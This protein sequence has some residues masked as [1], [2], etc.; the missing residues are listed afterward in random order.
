MVRLTRHVLAIVLLLATALEWRGLAQEEHEALL[1]QAVTARQEY[2]RS[3]RDLT[4]VE[5][6][7][8][9]ILRR[10]G[11]VDQRRTV[12][13]DFYV[14]QSRLDAD[15]TREYRITREVD[16]K[17]AADPVEQ[18]T[19]LFTAL[20]KARTRAQEDAALHRQNFKH[21]V[22]FVFW[23]LT[24]A[25]LVV[26]LREESQKDFKFFS[27][28]RE[29]LGDEEVLVLKYESKV[30]VPREP[31]VIFKRFRNPRAGV[32]GTV[33][34]DAKNGRLRRWVDD[35]MV[36]DDEIKAAGVLM[37]KEIAY[38]ESPLG[39]TPARIAISLFD[40][41]S[42]KKSP[43]FLRLTIRQTY[44]YEAFRRFEVSTATEIKKLEQH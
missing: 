35:W 38:T 21:V 14:Y 26:P 25:P 30:F 32:R 31:T 10:D 7:V 40:K 37:H 1:K 2:I 12:V 24:V 42:D 15:V 39:V 6:W 43:A 9:E 33:W 23:G 11:T 29:K 8:T 16:G 44:A 18:A 34:L 22:R 13:S 3:F 5:T 27:S 19:K 41:E 4:A 20:G 28:G 36:V 17:A